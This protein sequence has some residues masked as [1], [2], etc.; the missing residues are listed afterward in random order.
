MFCSIAQAG[1]NGYTSA[2]EQHHDKAIP[3]STHNEE[4]E[5]SIPKAHL[6]DHNGNEVATKKHLDAVGGNEYQAHL[7][8]HDSHNGAAAHAHDHETQ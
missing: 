2:H 7:A 8:H 4:H 3:A 5:K 6:H 1:T